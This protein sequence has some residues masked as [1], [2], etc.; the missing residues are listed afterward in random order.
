M[1][2]T[3]VMLSNLIN[4]SLNQ[5]S[6]NITKYEAYSHNKIASS[7]FKQCNSLTKHFDYIGKRLTMCCSWWT[8]WFFFSCVIIIKNEHATMILQHNTLIT[9]KSVA[10][11]KLNPRKYT[12][13]EWEWETWYQ[14]KIFICSYYNRLIKH[15]RHFKIFV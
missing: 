14:I 9:S 7:P 2:N 1:Q 13:V 3:F 12:H 8:N 10:L 15:F 5:N 6:H 11:Q 4:F